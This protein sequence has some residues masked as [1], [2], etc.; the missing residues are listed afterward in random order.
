MT[1]SPQGFLK[2]SIGE[3]GGRICQ[4]CL[5]PLT[6]KFHQFIC[7]S[8]RIRKDSFESFF[9][10][11]IHTQHTA[12]KL[13]S[14]HNRFTSTSHVERHKSPLGC[15]SAA[16]HTPDDIK[17]GSECDVVPAPVGGDVARSTV[18]SEWAV[19]PNTDQLWGGNKI[20]SLLLVELEP[21]HSWK[22]SMLDI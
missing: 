2:Y 16:G 12:L 9:K 8:R 5:W 3:N 11:P 17:P 1:I 4:I 6:N 10:Y 13:N 20:V 19:C 22:L 15:Q 7:S 14:M 18:W 21:P